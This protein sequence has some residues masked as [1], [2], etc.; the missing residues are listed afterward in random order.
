MEVVFATWLPLACVLVRPQTVA[1]P[2]LLAFTV[3]PSMVTPT[4]ATSLILDWFCQGVLV[5]GLSI[6]CGHVLVRLCK[7]NARKRSKN[8]NASAECGGTPS[9]AEKQ[10]GD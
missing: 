2:L 6:G 3:I 8:R 4:Y 1:V 9:V 5:F 7:L 10:H